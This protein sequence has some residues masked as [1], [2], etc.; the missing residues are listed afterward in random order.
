MTKTE[1]KK[2]IKIHSALDA[3]LGDTSPDIDLD[4]T[5]DEIAEEEPV[6]WAAQK[7]AALIGDDPWD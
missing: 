1:R 6:L 3:F 4:M 2:L 7:L 5:D